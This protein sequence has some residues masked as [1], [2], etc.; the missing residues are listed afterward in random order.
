MVRDALPPSIPFALARFRH[1]LVGWTLMGMGTLLAAQP[2]EMDLAYA[3]RLVN[4]ADPSQLD[5]WGKDPGRLPAGYEC[6]KWVAQAGAADGHSRGFQAIA[7]RN[8]EKKAV[9]IAFRGPEPVAD[10]VVDGGM[11]MAI[12][13]PGETTSLSLQIMKTLSDY[14][15]GRRLVPFMNAINPVAAPASAVGPAPGAHVH[16]SANQQARIAFEELEIPCRT[17]N[18]GGELKKARK[19]AVR[20]FDEVCTSLTAEAHAKMSWSSYAASWVWPKE[21]VPGEVGGFTVHVTGHSLGG[22]VAQIVAAG[23]ECHM[24]TF[25]APSASNHLEKTGVKAGKRKGLTRVNFIRDN[26]LMRGSGGSFGHTF[27]LSSFD[28]NPE[29]RRRL[30]HEWAR[31]SAGGIRG[32]LLANHSLE[33]IIHQFEAELGQARTEPFPHASAGPEEEKWG[34]TLPP[35]GPATGVRI[36]APSLE[37]APG[38][39]LIV[40]AVKANGTN[41]GWTWTATNGEITGQGGGNARVTARADAAEG[42]IIRIT[43]EEASSSSTSA[44]Q[45]AFLEVRVTRSQAV[46]VP[47]PPREEVKSV[48]SATPSTPAQAVVILAATNEVPPGGTLVLSVFDLSGNPP[49]WI[50]KATAGAF[51]RH[52]DTIMVLKVPQDAKPGTAITV[53]VEEPSASS[54]SAPRRGELTVHVKPR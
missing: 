1:R 43:A 32:Y 8:L 24:M 40:S 47:A 7:L 42:T 53:T 27:K 31:V 9:I 6:F 14:D 30:E 13:S 38:G 29:E 5:Q 23:R 49:I 21:P 18:P 46:P 17:A 22:F 37:V 34:P 52:D 54:S 50:W 12:V 36:V 16:L 45:R 2:S 28:A 35:A 3:C 25:A 4:F 33:G 20:F 10:V 15:G 48:A 41:P 44:P 19:E 26:D 11:M 51:E 39:E